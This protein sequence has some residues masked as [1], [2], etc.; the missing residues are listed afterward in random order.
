MKGGH[1]TQVSLSVH[2]NP[3]AVQMVPVGMRR[4]K[5]VVGG[6]WSLS[7]CPLPDADNM[8]KMPS[9]QCSAKYLVGWN[10]IKASRV[11]NDRWATGLCNTS[12]KGYSS[13]V[14]ND[15]KQFHNWL[16]FV[17]LELPCNKRPAIP[18]NVVSKL[19]CSS[20]DPNQCT[21]KDTKHVQYYTVWSHVT[22][23]RD[24]HWH[25]LPGNKKR[26]I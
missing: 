12:T 4:I 13:W 14:G 17:W 23:T 16:F 8:R 5:W 10:K 20:R 24:S 26:G 18:A 1:V 11:D 21:A 19:E 3:G 15:L 22:S 7:V 25:Y 2:V 9:R 6:S